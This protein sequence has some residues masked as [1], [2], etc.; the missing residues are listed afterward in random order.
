MAHPT[1]PTTVSREEFRAAVAATIGSVHQF[2]REISRLDTTLRES[3]QAEPDPLVAI[4]GLAARAAKDTERT[5][6]RNWFGQLF[7]PSLEEDEVVEDDTDVEDEEEDGQRKRKSQP[8]LLDSD[9]H[10][11]IVKLK[12]F[13][14]RAAEAPE[15]ELQYAVVG[16]WSCGPANPKAP[17]G[18][19]LELARYMLRRVVRAFDASS[20]TKGQRVTTKAMVKSKKGTRSIDRQVSFRVLSEAKR[21]PLYDLDSSAALDTVGTSIREHWAAATTS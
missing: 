12:L 21:V 2:Y 20:H 3:L 1:G 7:E 6:V 8:I 17:A 19:Q 13:D 14:P 11:L 4:G 10:M 16:D 15:P 5:N 9:R 18:Q